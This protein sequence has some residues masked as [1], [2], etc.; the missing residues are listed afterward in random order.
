MPGKD[1]GEIARTITVKTL[2]IPSSSETPRKSRERR[3][4]HFSEKSWEQLPPPRGNSPSPTSPSRATPTPAEAW[5]KPGS[6][7]GVPP[8]GSAPVRGRE[9]AGGWVSWLM[10]YKDKSCQIWLGGCRG[11]PFPRNLHICGGHQ[12]ERRPLGESMKSVES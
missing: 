4:W 11:A 12:A 9:A 8:P 2:E 6:R 5:W 1:D 10:V 7:A 3:W